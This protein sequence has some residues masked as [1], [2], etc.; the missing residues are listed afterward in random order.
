MSFTP[1]VECPRCRRPEVACYCAHLPKLT[2]RTRVL[3]LQH[4]RERDKAVGTA[5]MATLCLADAEVVVG[6]DFS[7]DRSVQA[8]L[9]C[10]TRPAALLYPGPTARD[11]RRDPPPHP[12]TLI[13]IDGTWHQ[14]KS[15]LRQN[16]WLLSLPHYAFEPDRPSEYRIRREPREDYVSTIEALSLTLGALEGD[17]ERFEAMLAPFRAMI[18]VQLSYAAQSNGG[19]RRARRRKHV[20]ARARLPAWLSEERLLCV[21]GEAN[22]WPY[23]RERGGPPYPHEL[24]HFTSLRLGDE[25]RFERVIAPRKPLSVSPIKHARLSQADL[26][27]G[28]TFAEFDAAFRAFASEDDVVCCWGHYASGLLREEGGY[29]PSRSVDVRKVAGDF[30]RRRPG[31]VEELVRDLRLDHSPVGKGRGGER[32]GMLVAVTR[33]LAEQARE[34]RATLGG[35]LSL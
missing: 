33:F 32:L 30:L 25:Q 13:A 16:P 26:E 2:T 3:V 5:R 1:R 20:T 34:E 8:A 31:S 12:V 10:P 6:I 11:V 22:A 9:S 27:Q 4:P 19:R 28:T 24:V 17:P 18:D 15:L 7:S 35:A 21:A 23:D 14:A 29:L